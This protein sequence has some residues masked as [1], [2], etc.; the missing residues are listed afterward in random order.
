MG[1][2]RPRRR[3]FP[4]LTFALPL[5]QS[6]GSSHREHA[7]DTQLCARPPC[8]HRRQISIPQDS[9]EIC[10]PQQRYA[11]THAPDVV[12]GWHFFLRNKNFQY[13]RIFSG[14]SLSMLSSPRTE[15]QAPTRRCRPIRRIRRIGRPVRAEIRRPPQGAQADPALLLPQ[16]H[17]P[18]RAGLRH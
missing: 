17:P 14:T 3:S 13:R 2:R 8:S 1:A 4:S 5:G 9:T 10:R 11:M 18:A 7:G 6:P 16:V 15:S 12:H